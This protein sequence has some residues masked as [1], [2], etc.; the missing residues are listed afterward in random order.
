MSSTT[1]CGES[2]ASALLMSSRLMRA[3][4]AKFSSSATISVSNVCNREVKRHATIP[5]LLRANQPE[6]RVLRE[7]LGI[8]DI[9]IARHAAVDGL[10]EQIGERKLG[11]LAPSR[12]AP[13]YGDEITQTQS[14]IQLSDHDEA[15]IRGDA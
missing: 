5:D 3:S 2:N 8:I 10:A 15:A 1:R 13:V 6:C 9:R 4:P 12:I 7:P 11:V 14:F